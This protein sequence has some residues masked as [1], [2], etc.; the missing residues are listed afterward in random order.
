LLGG[1][2]TRYWP[3]NGGNVRISVIEGN[4]G[5]R[6]K[7]GCILNLA[8]ERKAGRRSRKGKRA[9]YHQLLRDGR[10]K[11]GKRKRLTLSSSSC[12][13]GG[14]KEFTGKSEGKKE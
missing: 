14:K 4:G 10:K 8:V 5:G 1:E 3:T 9:E 2:K 13:K 7:R 11:G 12:Q 6:E